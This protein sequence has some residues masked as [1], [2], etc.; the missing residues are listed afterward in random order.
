MIL[1]PELRC[2]PH[3]RPMSPA[4]G[5]LRCPDGC[6]APVVDG[7]P[8]FVSSDGYASAFG[9]QWLRYRRTQL[10]SETKTTISRTRLERCL[11]RPLDR[12]RGASVLE[13][14]CGAGRF[15]ELLLEAGARVF[16]CDLS[17][18]VEANRDNCG[19]FPGYFVAQ[20]D[21]RALPARDAAFDVVLCLGVLQHTPRPEDAIRALAAKVKPGGLLV[22]DHYKALPG[23]AGLAAHVTPRALLRHALLR[24]PPEAAT[25]ASDAVTAAIL[26]FHRALWRNGAFAQRARRV[27]RAISPVLDYY[28]RHPELGRARLAEWA[29]LDTHDALTDRYKHLRD[30][31]QIRRALE[32]AGLESIEVAEAGNGIEARGR[33]PVQG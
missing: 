16:A 14:G 29:R 18:A 3:Q 5:S 7:I 4:E 12:L 21:I 19:H 31:G 6:R 9:T 26:P 25:R 24:L 15:T 22:V 10:D 20:A 17:R 11:G 2:A 23:A 8:R 32:D 27:L 33:R 30:A 28:D 1:P 13:A